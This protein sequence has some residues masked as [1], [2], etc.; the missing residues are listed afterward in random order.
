MVQYIISSSLWFKGVSSMLM[1]RHEFM[2][3]LCLRH[4]CDVT[5]SPWRSDAS[6]SL[7]S[8]VFSWYFSSK[9]YWV[10]GLNGLE[11]SWWVRSLPYWFDCLI[12]FLFPQKKIFV[13]FLVTLPYHC[14][15]SGP[16]R[17][18]FIYSIDDY[19]LLTWWNTHDIFIIWSCNA[20]IFLQLLLQLFYLY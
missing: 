13:V 19:V 9:K 18:N 7:M 11:M 2:W 5:L 14:F 3:N 15:L 4:F 8:Y 20:F 1:S 12:V 17:R 16:C 6:P 10:L